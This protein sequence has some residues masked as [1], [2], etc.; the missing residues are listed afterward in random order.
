MDNKDETEQKEIS[1]IMDD[2]IF[3]DRYLKIMK[4][5]NLLHFGNDNK[6]SN[7]YL[8]E[9]KDLI[10]EATKPKANTAQMILLIN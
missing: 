2:L 9:L 10:K 6:R 7:E 5:Q 4:L 3:D 1:S 8:N